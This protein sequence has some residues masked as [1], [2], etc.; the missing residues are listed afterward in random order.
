MDSMITRTGTFLVACL[1]IFLCAC[2]AI[3]PEISRPKLS[4]SKYYSSFIMSQLRSVE[5]QSEERSTWNYAFFDSMRMDSAKAVLVDSIL[6]FKVEV[7]E[8]CRFVD[9]IQSILIANAEGISVAEADTFRLSKLHSLGDPSGLPDSLRDEVG[10]LTKKLEASGRRIYT[11]DVPGNSP[12]YLTWDTYDM[13]EEGII[14]WEWQSMS[15]KTLE[16][17]IY[18][19]ATMKMR[20]RDYE[21]EVTT[22]LRIRMMSG[23][24]K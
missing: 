15:G 20:A 22:A 9:S 4:S 3:K 10:R 1:A 8:Y 17:I 7:N 12:E 24:L 16:Q 6:Q 14:S 21:A 13:D 2:P 18:V 23:N 5:K 19:F 11:G